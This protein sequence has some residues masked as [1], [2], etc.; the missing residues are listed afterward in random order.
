MKID[1]SG[2]KKEKIIIWLFY[3]VYKKSDAAKKT[4]DSL[5]ELFETPDNS[6]YHLTEAM[7]RELLSKNKDKL[8]YIG[9]VRL[10]V[11][12]SQD[13]I[14]VTDY[15]KTHKTGLGLIQ[16]AEGCINGF[17]QLAQGL[18]VNSFFAPE[19]NPVIPVLSPFNAFPH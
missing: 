7:V 3:N 15:D 8:E 17:K 5:N 16:T 14:D 18:K 12:L 9:P 19:D 13:E 6:I 1:I 2:L 4:E 10:M 11:D